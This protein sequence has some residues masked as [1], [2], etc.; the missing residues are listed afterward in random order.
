M[1]TNTAVRII[2]GLLQDNIRSEVDHLRAHLL[3]TGHF[4]E[5]EMDTALKGLESI[6]D[7]IDHYDTMIWSED[8]QT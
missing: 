7:R 1:K 2:L 6:A 8:N 5:S 3:S 4:L